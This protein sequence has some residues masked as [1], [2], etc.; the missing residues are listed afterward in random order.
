M[1]EFMEVYNC[2]NG[3]FVPKQDKFA[4]VKAAVKKF[5]DQVVADIK[6]KISSALAGAFAGKGVSF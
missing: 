5:A 3:E 6:S 1:V 4:E 2:I